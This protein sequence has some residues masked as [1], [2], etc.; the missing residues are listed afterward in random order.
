[1]NL[2][3]LGCG[4]YGMAC[5]DLCDELGIFEKIDFLDDNATQAIGKLNEYEKYVSSYENAF[6]AFG[7]PQ[8]RNQWQLHFSYR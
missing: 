5:K 2:L 3:I 4:G 1:M 8:L 7:N 6:I